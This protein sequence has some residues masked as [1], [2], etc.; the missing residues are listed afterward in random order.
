M[1]R[2]TYNEHNL[3]EIN[4]M[5]F[6][7]MWNTNRGVMHFEESMIKPLLKHKDLPDL[8]VKYSGHEKLKQI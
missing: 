4:K 8:R 2:R 3:V 5:T 1:L 6:D 7:E